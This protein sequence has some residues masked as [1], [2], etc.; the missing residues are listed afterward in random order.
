MYRQN[1]SKAVTFVGVDIKDDRSSAKSFVHD[2][3]ITYPIVYDEPGRAALA[4]GDLPTAGLPM[5]VLLDKQHRV[6]AVYSGKL[7]EA[8]LQPVLD[9]LVQEQ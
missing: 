9:R 6:A 5:T 7:T 4:L 8:D 2:Y 3:K 1:L